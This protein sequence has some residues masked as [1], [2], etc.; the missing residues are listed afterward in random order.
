MANNSIIPFVGSTSTFV[1]DGEPTAANQVVV[2]DDNEQEAEHIVTTP[3]AVLPASTTKEGPGG[4]NR[5]STD[6]LVRPHPEERPLGPRSA[7]R[8]IKLSTSKKGRGSRVN[9]AQRPTTGELRLKDTTKHLFTD[10]LP[11]VPLEEG[12]RHVF[13]ITSKSGN[14]AYALQSGGYRKGLMTGPS[15]KRKRDEFVDSSPRASK[16][17]KRHVPPPPITRPDGQYESDED[18]S[19]KGPKV[20]Q[21][22]RTIREMRKDNK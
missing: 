14:I 6:P 20:A 2:A 12:Q 17:V 11:P 4:A 3:L 18:M 8:S 5:G 7:P 22:L 16:M 21:L 9:T 10:P 19:L 1:L 13:S 15:P